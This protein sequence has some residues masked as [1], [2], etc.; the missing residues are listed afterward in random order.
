[1][2]EYT[3]GLD[4]GTES[5]RALLVE[6]STGQ[7]V[8]VA[9]HD[10]V[11]GVLA[12]SLPVEED[13][14]LGADW[15]L[16]VPGDYLTGLREVIPEV[17]NKGKARAG[18]VMGIGLDFTSC[19]LLPTD[20]KGTPLCRK[21]PFREDPQSWVKLWK[22][23][24][25]TQEARRIQEVAERRGE[26]FMDYFAH[27][28]SPE[29][30]LPKVLETKHRSPEIF[31]RAWTF[32]EACDWIP[33]RLTGKL[34]RNACC[35]GFKAQYN[36]SLGGYPSSAFLEAVEPGFGAFFD[37]KMPGPVIPPGEPVGGLKENW[38]EELGLRPGI[39]VAAGMIDAHMG[40]AGLG[41][42]EPG[43]MAL[44][45]GTS[46]CQMMLHSELHFGDG[47]LGIVRDAIMPGLYA[48]ESGQSAG[49]DIYAWFVENCVPEE[50]RAEA[51]RRNLTLHELLTEQAGELAPGENGLI[52]LDWWNGNRSILMD[53]ELSGLLLGATL[54]TRPEE[55]YRALIE[56]TAFGTR[57]IL[58]EYAND[59]ISVDGLVAC[60]G[61]PEKNEFAM[62][63]FTDICGLPIE[64]A[65]TSQAMALGSAMCAA[66]AAEGH[67]DSLPEAAREMS[68][69]PRSRY[70]PRPE[71]RRVYDRLYGAYTE[72]HDRF[73]RESD[74]MHR[75]RRI[76]ADAGN[77]N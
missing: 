53:A 27:A 33:W 8:A 58:E 54:K 37:E 42:T 3:I 39:P 13:G 6:V 21:E 17:M 10:Y 43:R 1:M 12:E 11:H 15:Y 68:H 34:A 51:E 61:L 62:Q 64:V 40:V 46:F 23:H 71:A 56:A 49:G 66:T 60:G 29:W 55:I 47:P 24:G 41:I 32:V 75:L 63:L 57:R 22:H 20:R 2:T 25:A 18:E 52:A 70:T 7:E 69:P 36:E 35:A 28:I 30:L 67:Y 38:A 48:Y 50:Y 19:T 65:G 73:G 14:E 31:E 4:F 59:G 44:V 45:L 16:Q 26:Q 5:V 74:L 9:D 72:L 77:R 76:R